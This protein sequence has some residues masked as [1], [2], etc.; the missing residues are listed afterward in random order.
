MAAPFEMP[1]LLSS[2]Q[3]KLK[4]RQTYADL[5]S[6]LQPIATYVNLC[7]I[8]AFGVLWRLAVERCLPQTVWILTLPIF[9]HFCPMFRLFL[10]VFTYVP[11]VLFGRHPTLW[12]RSTPPSSLQ[13]TFHIKLIHIK[14]PQVTVKAITTNSAWLHT[15]CW[16][17]NLRR[18]VKFCIFHWF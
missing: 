9:A 6:L 15:A 2:H 17:M 8:D 7:N 10:L 13:A 14:S 5:C 4:D 1:V 18:G 11:D 16:R 3:A 12:L